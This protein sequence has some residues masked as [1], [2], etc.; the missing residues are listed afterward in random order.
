MCGSRDSARAYTAALS[1]DGNAIAAASTRRSASAPGAAYP[2][3][4][5][6]D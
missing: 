2:G 5:L 6:G 4:P 3:I 1:A